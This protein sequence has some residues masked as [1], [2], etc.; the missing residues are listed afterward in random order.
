MWG[1]VLVQEQGA[2]R[3]PLGAFQL[4]LVL[5]PISIR[6]A[7]GGSCAALDPV[8]VWSVFSWAAKCHALW[9]F[10]TVWRAANLRQ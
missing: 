3:F 6:I 8:L 7:L 4:A 10:V 1:S 5:V 9:R 2:G